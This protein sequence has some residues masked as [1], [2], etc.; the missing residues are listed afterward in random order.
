M[1]GFAVAVA[2]GLIV[3]A[4]SAGVL[5]LVVIQLPSYQGQIWEWV[6]TE[7][8]ISL[9]FSRMDARW[10]LLGPEFSFRDAMVSRVGGEAN[11]IVSAVEAV[12]TLSPLALLS[13]RRLVVNRLTLEGSTLRLE[14]TGDG[15]LRLANLP[16]DG[17]APTQLSLADI[18]P[19][20]LVVSG[21][22]V[23]YADEIRQTEWA[24]DDVRVRLVRELGSIVIEARAN[25]PEGLAERIEV[26]AQL[27]AEG[28]VQDPQSVWRL[29]GEARGLD[30]AELQNLLPEAWRLTAS[31]AGD[32]SFWVDFAGNEARQAT[33]AL[34][35]QGLYV[36]GSGGAGPDYERIN[37]TLEGSR[38]DTGWAI[39]AS[40]LELNR[41]GR[42]W[43]AGAAID[44][45][46]G[47][48]DA[49]LSSLSVNSS[50][51]RLEDLAPLVATLPPSDIAGVWSEL[52]PGGEVRDV[53]A[54]LVRG[55][56]SWRYAAVGSF[57]DLRIEPRDAWPGLQGFSGRLRMDSNSGRLDLD[58][59]DA[60]VDWPGLF[61]G[62]ID[63]D[64]LGGG[65]TWRQDASALRLSSDGLVV[66]TPEGQSR[67]VLELTWPDGAGG[68]PT[69]TL[70]S[71]L[72]NLDAAG[73]TRYFP[74]GVFPQVTAYLSRAIVGGRV[75]R[76]D[77]TLAGPLAS[78]PFGNGEGRF[79]AEG[80]I[81]GGTMAYV[82]DWPAAEDLNGVL[83][84]TDA[85]WEAAGSGRVLGNLSDNVRV[86][87]E[88]MR[89]PVLSV[90]ASTRGPLEEALRYLK[91]AEM[92][93][94]HL[95]PDLERLQSGSG[96][97]DVTFE[98]QLPLLDLTAYELSAALEISGGG[99]SID[100]FGPAVTGIDGGLRLENG[101]VLSRGNLVASFLD[102]PVSVSVAA[103][104]EPGYLADIGFEGVF[105]AES[106]QEE[107]NLPFAGLIPG[108][109]G[110]QGQVL[111]PENRFVQGAAR[112][113]QDQ[114][115]NRS[116]RRGPAV[117]RTAGEAA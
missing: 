45:Q 105:P 85:G 25:P 60:R 58:T 92:I 11:P 4:M 65:L 47:E 116:G 62:P 63:V 91:E 38:L 88:D 76:A 100:G 1:R 115:G 56:G 106:L 104:G 39:S 55:H 41:A 101:Q 82:E 59:R 14:R 10:S 103:A 17:A 5:R 16:E 36:G 66:N 51:L 7:L 49:G 78:F 112:A 15:T 18:P 30:L 81:E 117:S 28:P 9:E 20:T 27:D 64:E 2:T 71:E 53:E 57:D 108:A 52:Q 23:T 94:R 86:G 68:A 12:I 46:I 97:A 61:S 37:V 44:V 111:L 102:A 6:R 42:A 73:A 90:A 74:V 26:S 99:L 84:F 31:G 48:D 83:T 110:W 114:P 113:A 3:L 8:G 69:V 35:L 29:F 109:S 70:Q 40:N 54:R 19:V 95:G 34:A 24:F 79:H 75:P 89:A 87:I 33:L 21:G 98:L 107:F 77:V 80:R 22:S 50:F 67:S 43:P 96:T 13:E 72:R 32:V 93:A